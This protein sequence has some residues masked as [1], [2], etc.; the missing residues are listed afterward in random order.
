MS[1]FENIKKEIEYKGYMTETQISL[2]LSNPKE[3]KKTLVALKNDPE[4]HIVEYTNIYVAPYKVK[5]LY[6]YN[7]NIKKKS[8]AKKKTSPKKT[9]ASQ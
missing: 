4:I 8:K 6:L 2:K 3:I 7:P 5:Q 9:Q 1:S